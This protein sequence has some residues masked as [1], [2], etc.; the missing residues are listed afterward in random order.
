MNFCYSK[1]CYF[2][3]HRSFSSYH[4]GEYSSSYY[5][6][7]YFALTALLLHVGAVGFAGYCELSTKQLEGGKGRKEG[8]KGR[9]GKGREGK[10]SYSH[11][12]VYWKQIYIFN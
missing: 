10:R 9:E 1:N 5:A 3:H 4:G 2:V 6:G 7:F 8:R 12:F 11:C